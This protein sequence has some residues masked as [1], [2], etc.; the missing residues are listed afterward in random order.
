MANLTIED[1]YRKYGEPFYI[2]S[3]H[4]I[5]KDTEQNRAYKAT[6]P[7]YFADGTVIVTSQPWHEP[8]D[9]SSPHPSATEMAECMR[10]FGFRQVNLTD[11]QLLDGTIARN[12]K[13]GDFIK[14]RDR[15]VPID[16]DLEKP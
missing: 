12:V 6:L 8:A 9:H 14:T 15:V 1:C 11:W 4:L 7:G 2:G 16:I 13:P 3:K 10:G 5:W